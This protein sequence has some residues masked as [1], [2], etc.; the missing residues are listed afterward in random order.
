MTIG[1]KSFQIAEQRS[2]NSHLSEVRVHIDA[3]QPPD[4]AVSPIAPF[5]RMHDLSNDLIGSASDEVP[6]PG[7]VGEQ[8]FHSGCDDRR[9]QDFSFGFLRQASIEF[10][11][12]PPIVE[13]GRANGD[14]QVWSHNFIRSKNG[15]RPASLSIHGRDS[16]S[17]SSLHFHR[18]IRSAIKNVVTP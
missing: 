11:N 13:S 5:M 8:R 12:D 9:I 4:F 2:K 3:L 1:C 17:W 14:V 15:M 6:T 10:R 18:K 7:R 16:V